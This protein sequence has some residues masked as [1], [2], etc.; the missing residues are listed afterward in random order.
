[1][2]FHDFRA[3]LLSTQKNRKRKNPWE[4]LKTANRIWKISEVSLRIVRAPNAHVS[5]NKNVTPTSLRIKP[6]ISFLGVP[7]SASLLLC[8]MATQA[9]ITNI[10]ELNIRMTVMGPRKAPKNTRISPMK[11]LHM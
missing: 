7:F 4:E 8:L 5:P 2:C 11:Q 3:S 6:N 1:M 9:T 10:M